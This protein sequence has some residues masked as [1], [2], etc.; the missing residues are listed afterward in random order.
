MLEL[1]RQLCLTIESPVWEAVRRPA[2][3]AAASQPGAAALAA[4]A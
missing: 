1:V 4:S 2:P 3:W